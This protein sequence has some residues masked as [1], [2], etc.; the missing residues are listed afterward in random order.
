MTETLEKIRIID[1]T[2]L[3]PGPFC[4]QMLGDLGA[5]VIKIED[6]SAGDY[7]R[8]YPPFGQTDSA[9]YLSLNRNKKSLS[10]DLSSN[11]G[12]EVFLKMIPGADVVIEQFRPGVM[13]RLGLSYEKLQVINP[14]LIMCSISGYGQ[15]GIYKEKAGHDIN[16]LSVAGILD[17]IGNDKGAPVIPG[18]QIADIG[19]GS[20]WAAFSIMTALFIREQTGR[21]QYIDVSMMDTVFTYTCMLA[22]AYF[23]DHRI[24]R[25]GEELLNGGYAWYNV[26]KTRDERY[27]ALGM[28]EA[29]FWKIFCQVIGRKNWIKK[30]FAPLA[31]QRDMIEELGTIFAGRKCDEW[32]DILGPLDICVSRINSLDEAINDIHLRG[33]GMIVE[34]NH[35][36]EGKLPTLGF[37]IKFSELN[38]NIRLPPPALGQHTVD[39]LRE[40]GYSLEE[41]NEFKNKQII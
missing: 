3:L 6:P 2:R 24:P 9:L 15:T 35:P 13:E 18:I 23:M 38:C 11:E 5:E 20:L 29:K 21:G 32:M 34:M 37:P 10:L 12:L 14:R 8:D 22:G 7:I 33:R 4:T 19:G 25:R 26:Y 16:Y 1:L 30:Q 17:L 28:L 27:I 31:V 39:L 36:V 40:H 41:I